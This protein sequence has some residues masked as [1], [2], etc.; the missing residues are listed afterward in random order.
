MLIHSKEPVSVESRYG[1]LEK[2]TQTW[3]ENVT[4]VFTKIRKYPPI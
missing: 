3:W 2:Q 4:D 1:G